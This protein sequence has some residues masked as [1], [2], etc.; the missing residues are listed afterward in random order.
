[1]IALL[2]Y[3]AALLIGVS[4][5]LIGAG[6]AI[7]TIPVLVYLFG[8]APQ[9]ATTYSLFIVGFSAL[10]GSIGYIR[11]KLLSY[12]TAIGF[13]IA[14]LLSVLITRKVIFPVIPQDMYPLGVHVSKDKFVLY[15]FAIIMIIASYSM[16]RKPKVITSDRLSRLRE[17]GTTFLILNGVVVGVLAGLVGAGGGFL[18]VPALVV[19]Q[20]LPMKVAIGTS[21]LII[22]VNSFIGFAADL[23]HL[24][25]DWSLLASLSILALAGI[26]IGLALSKKIP[27]SRLKPMFGWFILI[28]GV[29]IIA[30]TF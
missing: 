14:S 20:E 18:I 29:Y 12:K 10:T 22:A 1:M 24:A 2:G 6:G 28:M 8:I 13:G 25:I 21:L 5:G 15:V 16:I 17:H 7:L 26:L 9:T 11:N 27:G 30:K 23:G 3:P 19:I 4:L